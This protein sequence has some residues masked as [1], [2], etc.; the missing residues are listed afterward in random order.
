[1]I[2]V[3]GGDEISRMIAGK[4]AKQRI[5]AHYFQ[6]ATWCCGKNTLDKDLG[7]MEFNPGSTLTSH[8]TLIF[9]SLCFLIGK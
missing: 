5:V 6:E 1:M 2:S 4:V 7:T 8:M 9:L 3:F